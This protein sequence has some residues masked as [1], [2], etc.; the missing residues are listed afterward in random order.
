MLNQNAEK[1]KYE[2]EAANDSLQADVRKPRC[3]TEKSFSL[4]RDFRHHMDVTWTFRA[5]FYEPNDRGI[6]I[7]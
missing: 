2:S 5:W 6:A 3:D 4:F 1:E 7:S